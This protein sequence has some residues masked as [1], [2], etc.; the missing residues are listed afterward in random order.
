MA[1]VIALTGSPSARSRTA[2]LSEH[3]ALRLQAAGHEVGTVRV[4]DLPA[5]ALL[6]ADAA[7]PA[8]AEVVAAIEAADGLVVASPV[9]K[10]AYSGVLKILL[11]LLPQ[12]ALAG[13]VVLPVV[14]GGT[15]VHL[16]AIDYAL[17]PVLTSLGAHHVVKGCFVLDQHIAFRADAEGGGI[18]LDP[19]SAVPLHAAVDVFAAALDTRRELVAL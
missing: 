9:Y 16:L 13:K 10:A 15:P 14:T 1:S 18:D 5:D 7:N 11:D 17:R 2:A 8:I 3:I 12:H 4:R 19:A 6:A